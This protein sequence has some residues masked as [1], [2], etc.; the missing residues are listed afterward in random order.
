MSERLFRTARRQQND[1]RAAPAGGACILW[2]WGCAILLLCG[3]L[4]AEPVAVPSG[5]DLSLHEVLLDDSSGDLLVRFRFVAPDIARDG[6]SVA[7]AEA[8]VDMAHLCDT[9]VTPYLS[10]F[11]LTPERVVISLADR[12]VP[13]GAS[14]PDAT[15][16]F[17][18]Y[19]L[20]SARCIL[21]E[22]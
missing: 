17:E 12:P 8:A 14:D 9:W 11:S 20:E 15:Q 19:R 18:A 10:D 2:G 3:P 5:Q 13:F 7:F 6:G 16:F 1:A 21:E 22:F 4:A